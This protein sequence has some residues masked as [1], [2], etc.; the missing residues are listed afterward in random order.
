MS[1]HATH[2]D[3][4][5]VFHHVDEIAW[6]PV[7]RQ[8]NADG[9]ESV[10]RER[11]PIIRPGFLSA[12]VHYES[13]MVVRRHGHRSNHVV[14]VLGGGAWIGGDWCTAGTHFHVPLGAAF[15]PIVAGPEGVTCWEL[16]FGE[17]G[18]WGDQPELYEREIAARG[19]T[20]LP[21]P[22][23]EIGPWF[24]DPRGDWGAERSSPKVEGL[25]E[26]VVRLDDLPWQDVP[27]AAPGTVREKR[28]VDEPTFRSAFVA[29]DPGA[30]TPRV[31]HAGHLLLLV[32]D[33]G[34][35]F[36]DRWCPAGTHVE[37]PTGGVLG[38]VRAG[39]DGVRYL[40][41]T[42][43]DLRTEPA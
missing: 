4:D 28:P 37:V 31:R 36:G 15:G 6:T 7:Q 12:Y 17:F 39:D 10:I 19:V 30:S 5:A 27:G 33:G 34:A 1:E 21:D 26:R 11:W 3:V 32:T 24:T 35:W 18:G 43:G 42:D 29:L 14:F 2:P 13:G 38:P 20:P 9:T 8:Q 23:L 40:G 25:A 16:S 41:V 22:P